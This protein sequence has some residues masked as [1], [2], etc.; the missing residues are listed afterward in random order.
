MREKAKEV[1]NS[2]VRLDA[3]RNFLAENGIVEGEEIAPKEDSTS[4]A[5][6]SDLE[7]QLATR[8]R[9]HERTDREL[10]NMIQQKRDM[11]AQKR[12]AEAQIE[13]LMAALDEMKA[14]GPQQNGD[15][16]ARVLELE[17]KLEETESSYKARL[18]QLEEDYQLAVHYVK[19]VLVDELII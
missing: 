11:E 17:Q 2:A 15:S 8:S 16:D 1:A 3:L 14:S 9:M 7:D 19:C 10:Q 5:R 13:T 18:Q 6:L 12:D 4:L